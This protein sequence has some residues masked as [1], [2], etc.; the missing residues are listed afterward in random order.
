MAP[1]YHASWFLPNTV[2][3]VTLFGC[4]GQYRHHAGG[5]PMNGIRLACARSASTIGK[6]AA[7]TATFGAGLLLGLHGTGAAAQA[8]PSKPV[9]VIT[10]AAAGSL[11]DSVTRITFTRVS[12]A[13]GQPFIVD[14]RPGAGGNISAVLVAKSPPDGHTLY[15]TVQTV[16]VVNPF[17]YARPGFDTLRDFEP[18]SMV[19]KVSEVL[20]VHPSLGTKSLAELVRLAEARPGQISYA[21]AG[22][23]HPTH[24]MLE[25]IQRK[26]GIQLSH[27][28]YKGTPQAVLAVVSGEVGV[29][30]IGIGLVR[31][32]IASGKLVALTKTG[33]PSPDALPG[34][35]LLTA[36]YPDAEY[37]P[38]TATFAPKG[39]PSEI[40]AK[41]NST[42]A[43][44]LA[45]PDTV[46]KLKELDLTAAPGSPADLEKTIRADMAVNRELVK[47][48]GLKLD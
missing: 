14:N 33:H 21:S 16:M 31:P 26:A 34:V 7:R 6:S 15:L 9:R 47:S 8:Y 20:V 25:L 17:L 3:C 4:T 41:L 36:T 2:Y 39:T 13:L 12:E 19:A 38:W 18:I 29:L 30:N 44:A 42:I 11:A 43:R 22:N 46:S 23:G 1:D 5:E 27:V 48:I 40:V 24:L 37:V 45:T 10:M 28:P 35:P 32:H